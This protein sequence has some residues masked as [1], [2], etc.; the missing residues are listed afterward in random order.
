MGDIGIAASIY[1][2]L[3]FDFIEQL[4]SEPQM[5]SALHTFA[6]VVAHGPSALAATS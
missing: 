4:E 5:T 3:D 6:S 2:L 1:S